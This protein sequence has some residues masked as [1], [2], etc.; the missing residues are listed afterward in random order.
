MAQPGVLLG[1]GGGGGGGE[2]SEKLKGR[3]SCRI[4]FL[5]SYARHMT[6]LRLDVLKCCAV[7]LLW[8]CLFFSLTQFVILEHLSIL[9]LA[10]SGLK[11]LILA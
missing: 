6:T 11:G 3:V 8:C 1:G 4:N 2:E 10:L 7:L 9:D 5:N